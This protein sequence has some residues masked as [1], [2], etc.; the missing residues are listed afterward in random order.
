MDLLAL[1]VNK[2]CHDGRGLGY[3]HRYSV[4]GI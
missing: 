2:D 3:N 4:V 1:D